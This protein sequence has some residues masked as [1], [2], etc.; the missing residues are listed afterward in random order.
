[1]RLLE[2]FAYNFNDDSEIRQEKVAALLIAGSCCIAG[3]IWTL[4][5]YLIFGIGLT[6]FLPFLFVVIVGVCIIIAHY[7]KNHL[8][9]IYAQ[10]ICIIYITSFIQ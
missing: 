6:T 2:K 3:G 5:Y 1:M 4:M 10:I 7:Q 9:A 8:W